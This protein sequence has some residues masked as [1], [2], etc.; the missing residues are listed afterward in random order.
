MHDFN[1]MKQNSV[2]GKMFF[3][4]TQEVTGSHTHTY[5]WMDSSQKAGQCPQNQTVHLIH[6]LSKQLIKIA[7]I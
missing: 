5:I 7:F 2:C 3:R 4:G 6:E 1:V